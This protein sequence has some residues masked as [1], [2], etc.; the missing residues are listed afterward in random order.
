M[1]AGLILVLL[2]G[3]L[4]VL[5]MARA[6]RSIL[7][8]QDWLPVELMGGELL[9][10]ERLFLG[11][12]PFPIVARVDRAY[13]L[14]GQLHLVELK[15]RMSSMVFRTDVIELSAQ[16]AAIQAS[17]AFKVSR[18]G[19]VVIQNAATGRRIV[20]KVEL[21]EVD[22]V[23]RLLRRRQAILD[24][25]EH[26]RETDMAERC[27]ACEYHGECKGQAGARIYPLVRKS[28]IHAQR[29]GHDK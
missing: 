20:R 3:G 19:I 9:F 29:S 27:A 1:T 11:P 28:S 6:T 17:T 4:Y 7:R 26:P 16:R 22:Q 25:R 10:S 14:N 13:L 8:E 15:R 23:E 24:G 18:T 21:I 2:V 5:L 12:G